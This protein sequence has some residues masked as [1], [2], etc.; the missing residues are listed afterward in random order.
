MR[1]WWTS[2]LLLTAFLAS[3]PAVAQEPAGE[4]GGK[5]QEPAADSKPEEEAKEPPAFQL[6]E[7]SLKKFEKLLS[8]YLRPNKK[9]RA[10]RFNKLEKFVH[11]PIGGHSALEDVPAIVS[12]ANHARIF[13][14][15]TGKRGRVEMVSVKPQVH[16]FPGGIG[17][18]SYAL[19][20][21]KGYSDREL[22]PLIF[23]LPD[24]KKWT[25]QRAYIKEQWLNRSPEAAGKFII[26]VPKPQS[27]GDS[28]MR[29]KSTARA[30]I[31]LRHLI[32]T[33]DADKKNGGPAIDAT[34]VYIEGDDAAA[35]FAG[36]YG[37]IF[38]GAILRGANGK[39]TDDSPDLRKAGGLSGLPAFC[40]YNS[41]DTPQREFAEKLK[42]ASEGTHLAPVEGD[43]LDGDAGQIVKWIEE[44]AMVNQ[45]KTIEF[46]VWDASFQRH[47]WIV[48]RDFDASVDP[49]PNFRATADRKTNEVRIE[50]EGINRFELFLNDALV[51]LNSKIRIV[52]VEGGKEIVFLEE[53][54]Q[55]KLGV[56]LEEM[57]ASNHA[58]R[59]Y[60]VQFMLDMPTLRERQRLLDIEA[61]AKK[62]AE[63]GAAGGA[64]EEAEQ[65]D[66]SDSAVSS[67]R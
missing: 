40:I 67:D 2:F 35:N 54:V 16:G 55:R 49:A 25:D 39:A 24:N 41:K 19:Y 58:W 66:T 42:V 27:R 18:V 13:G 11:V 53:K 60:P 29:R 44:T 17:T 28:W 43:A 8:E 48:V 6:P 46:Y 34:R 23:C 10:D 65:K 51:D 7:R 47:H 5:A 21:P 37:E 57:L 26:A 20:L 1:I 15:K 12:I 22:W 63:K 9:P 36:R 61:A 56:M 33:F 38:A 31:A 50:V 45:P 52:V 62:A 64:S 14:S 3:Q 32:G 4:G 59:A 30:M